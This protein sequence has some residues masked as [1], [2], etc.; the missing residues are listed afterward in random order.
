M[1]TP[2]LLQEIKKTAEKHC[3]VVKLYKD[4]A[5][6]SKTDKDTLIKKEEK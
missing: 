3:K 2:I 6:N 5:A 1:M 4:E